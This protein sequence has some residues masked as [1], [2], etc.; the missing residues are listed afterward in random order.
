MVSYVLDTVTISEMRKE[1][2]NASVIRFL[3]T[4]DNE[5][6]FL[7]VMTI[8]EIFDGID[9]MPFGARRNE[10]LVWLLDI[11]ESYG[12]RIIS[13]DEAIAERWGQLSALVHRA[14]GQLKVVD[15]LIAATA[16]VHGLTV[17]TRNA[18]DF[19]PTG[20]PIINPWLDEDDA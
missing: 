16:Q 19:E 2:S 12:E 6:L 10:F 8:G 20:V 1:P 13:V 11:K 4:T 15:G 17:V 7:S 5:R 18:K 9:R 3:E 14:G